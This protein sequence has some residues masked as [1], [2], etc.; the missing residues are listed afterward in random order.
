MEGDAVTY[1][2]APFEDLD[3]VLSFSDTAVTQVL[4]TYALIG[5]AFSDS[6][7]ALLM[8]NGDIFAN[9]G[10]DTTWSS[11][12]PF[13]LTI[14]MITLDLLAALGLPDEF[15]LHPAYPNPFNSSATL[16]YDL[17]EVS[18]VRLTVYDLRGGRWPV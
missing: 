14:D 1:G 9:D 15:A 11:N 7:P 13:T 10:T 17:P 8:D 18:D 5:A 12:G 4:F 16:H 6:G 2:A 3:E